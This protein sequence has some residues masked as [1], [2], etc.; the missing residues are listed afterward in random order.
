MT[1]ASHLD[2]RVKD[3][4]QL[5][6]SGKLKRSNLARFLA[7][8]EESSR[9]LMSNLQRASELVNGFKRIAVDQTSEAER[10]YSL[11]EL[12]D[13]LIVSLKPKLKPSGHA[14]EVRG[15][16]DLRI[17]G[18]PGAL[19]KTITNFVMNS[20]IHAYDP[21]E[22]GHLSI[23]LEDAGD[24]VVLRYTDDGAGIRPDVVGRVFEPFFTTRRGQGGSGLGLGLHIVYNLVT[25]RMH[26]KIDVASTPG[27]GTTFTLRLPKRAGGGH[28]AA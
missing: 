15:D 5:V 17:Y 9:L 19:S 7:T 14:V 12:L 23:E 16:A 1:A 24:D 8:V 13:A 28:G 25:Q 11:R 10:E 3:F 22:S 6:E 4:R 21:G 26:G 2:E 20:I 27:V 18:D